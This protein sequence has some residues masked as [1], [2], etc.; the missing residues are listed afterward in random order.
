MPLSDD[1]LTLASGGL[2]VLTFP[3]HPWSDEVRG[4]AGNLLE[5]VL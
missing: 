5:T 1:L 3:N 2:A 4:L